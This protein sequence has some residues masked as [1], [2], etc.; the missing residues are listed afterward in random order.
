MGRQ[1]GLVLFGTIRLDLSG[2]TMGIIGLEESARVGEIA[3]LW[4]CNLYYDAYA[5][6]H[7]SGKRF[8]WKSYCGR[9][10]WSVCIV[11]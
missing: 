3:R 6:G 8:L 2:R 11:R 5:E 10:M 1:C 4:E 9:V 7:G